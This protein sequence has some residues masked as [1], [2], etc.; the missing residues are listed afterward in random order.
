MENKVLFID[1]THPLLPQMLEEAG[2]VCEHFYGRGKQEL[3]DVVASYKGLIVR[4]GIRIDKEIIDKAVSLKFIGRVGAG[5]ENI[6]TVYA[7]KKGVA[8][9]KA[10]EGN[11]DAVAE[12]ALGMLLALN[13]KL[14][15]ADTQVRQGIW[16]RE[17][18]R[19]TEINGKTLGIIG[20]GNMGSAFAKRLSGFGLK[21]LAY[22]KYKSG[23]GND[24]VK[25]STMEELFESCDIVSLHL[26]LTAETEFL[27]NDDW[28]AK[29][30]KPFVLINTA[31]GK[32]VK[33]ASLVQALKEGKLTGACLDVLEYE[34]SSFEEL[35]KK[36]LPED[37]R[38]LVAS[39]KVVFS[40]HIAGWTHE[41]NRK[42]AEVT[43]RKII[44]FC[45]R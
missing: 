39:S 19:G 12:H 22:D 30:K 43:A 11:R 29:F 23:F 33:T 9:F 38:Y 20:F 13:N 5:T 2:F 17:E 15:V 41:S 7:E 14:I 18:N 26:P 45:R 1:T 36:E 44:D 21:V 31:R 4:S 10:P 34:K 16:K 37:F 42:L 28:L 8:C 3:L 35:Y 32:I 40:P 27:V 6:D 24:L 25:E